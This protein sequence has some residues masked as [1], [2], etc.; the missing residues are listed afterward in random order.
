MKRKDLKETWVSFI[1]MHQRNERRGF[2]EILY[3]QHVQRINNM[4]STLDNHNKPKLKPIPKYA[5]ENKQRNKTIQLQNAELLQ[6]LAKIKSS[7]QTT[8]HVSVLRQLRLKQQ[9]YDLQRELKENKLTKA[10]AELSAALEKCKPSICFEK[11][12]KD[13]RKSRALMKN[14]SLYPEYL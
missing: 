7:I 3:Q 1:Q 9:L 5:L 10:N 12:E 4:K 14:M 2:D 11:F 8:N 6:R 13:F